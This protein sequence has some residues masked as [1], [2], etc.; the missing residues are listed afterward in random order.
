MQAGTP[1]DLDALLNNP[2]LAPYKTSLTPIVE[3]LKIVLDPNRW[4]EVPS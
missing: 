3:D 2:L 1:G 4:G